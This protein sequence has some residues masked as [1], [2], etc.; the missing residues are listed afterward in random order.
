MENTAHQHTCPTC[1][2]KV[3]MERL[4][5]EECIRIRT[6]AARH[7]H[8]TPLDSLKLDAAAHYLDYQHPQSLRNAISEKRLDL[9]TIKIGGRVRVPITQLAAVSVAKG[10]NF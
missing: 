6:W 4:I 8:S 10:M 7:G 3:P 5:A 2:Q 9:T 1:A